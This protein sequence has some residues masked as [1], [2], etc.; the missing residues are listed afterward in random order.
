[1]KQL[2]K[3]ML[4]AVAS[5]ALATSAY[6]WDFGASGSSSATFKQETSA[7]A[8]GDA[9][10]TANFTS[11]AGGVTVSSSNSD[12]A[13][14]ATFSYT[15]D[16]NGDDSNFDESVSVSGSKKV[17]NWT[18]SSAT[19][20]HIQ[21]DA[22]SVTGAQPMTAGAS[23]VITLTDGSITYKLG[24]TGHLSTAEKAVNG[25]MS[26]TQDA[27]A[28]V[29]SFNGFSVGLGVGPGTLTVALDMHSGAAA[30]V[31]GEN[32]AGGDAA[33]ACGGGQATGFGLNFAG[34]VGADLTFTYGSGGFALSANCTGDNSSNAY[35]YNV[36][37]LG[38]A[39]P[40]GGMSLAIDYGSKVALWTNATVEGGTATGGWELSFTLPVGD[41][42]AG[43]NLSSTATVGT[44]AGVAGDAAVTGGTEL[45][46]TV[47]I[48][49]AS[50]SAGYGSSAVVD[51]TTTTQIGAEMSLSF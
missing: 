20:Q 21:K 40:I 10:T 38:V 19:T 28:S 25:P 5:V 30:T 22:T 4:A 9:T 6:A 14:S 42:T 45:W 24:S 32:V 1:M 37:G 51:G 27:E 3:M 7:P 36:M 8:E 33:L 43:I 11:S 39:V 34:D 49:A 35:S 13:N 29:D 23:A 17:G 44:T 12:G 50:L 41:A 2:S 15:A 31:L 48:G 47:P 16:W 46:Y 18:A 26:G